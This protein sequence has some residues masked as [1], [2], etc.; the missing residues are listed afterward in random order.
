VVVGKDVKQAGAVAGGD[1]QACAGAGYGYQA[2]VV[3]GRDDQMLAKNVGMT[4]DVNQAGAVAGGDDQ[5]CTAAWYGYQASVVVGKDD[6]M[7]GL[8]YNNHFLSFFLVNTGDLVA[9]NPV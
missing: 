8:K 9:M 3:V 2:S 5:A 7:F 1:D 4:V 6:Q